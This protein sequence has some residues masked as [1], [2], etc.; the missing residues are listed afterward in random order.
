MCGSKNISIVKVQENKF[1]IEQTIHTLRGK[2]NA[3]RWGPKFQNQIS[4]ASESS[5]I[6]IDRNRPYL[7]QYIINIDGGPVVSFE[8]QQTED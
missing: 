2:L 6:V 8:W 3:L 5:I 1:E 4:Y 7:N